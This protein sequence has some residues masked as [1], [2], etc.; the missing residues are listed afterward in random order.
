MIINDSLGFGALGAIRAPVKAAIDEADGIAVDTSKVIEKYRPAS[1]KIGASSNFTKL[2]QSLESVKRDSMSGVATDDRFFIEKTHDIRD[3]LLTLRNAVNVANESLIAEA[4]A[5]AA[6]TEAD[7]KA[8]EEAARKAEIESRRA[9]EEARKAAEEAARKASE[10]AAA[11]REKTKKIMMAAGLVVALTLGV[12][13][14][15]YFKRR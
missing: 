8:A 7:K 13:G 5:A 12:V 11:E 9:A 4:K 1:R 2:V 15:N 3:A 14:Y 10:E 6:K